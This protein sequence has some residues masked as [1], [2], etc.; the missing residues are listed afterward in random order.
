MPLPQ[1]NKQ[2]YNV[3]AL[4][5]INKLSASEWNDFITH[6]AAEL[7]EM[8]RKSVYD[9]NDDGV[10]NAAHSAE[11]AQA[12]LQADTIVDDGT[13]DGDIRAIDPAD[14]T[15]KW[16]SLIGLLNTLLGGTGWQ[17]GGG[18]MLAADYVDA[19]GKGVVRSAMGI[20]SSPD[21]LSFSR[22]S[23]GVSF[24]M[25]GEG[26]FSKDSSGISFDGS[27]TFLLG[28]VSIG[29]SLLRNIRLF[30]Y[31]STRD[32]GDTTRALYTDAGGNLRLGAIAG[33]A[34]IADLPDSS[35]LNLSNT[36]GNRYGVITAQTH[37]AYTIA[38][39]PAP[40]VGAV[41]LLRQQSAL[42]PTFPAEVI[43][44]NDFTTP[45]NPNRI[46]HIRLECYETTPKYLA[47]Y[48]GSEPG[49][50]AAWTPE[51]IAAFWWDVASLS[52]SDG[53]TVATL[54]DE[55]EGVNL[56]SSAGAPTYD[57]A[58]GML[59]FQAASNQYLK[60]AL[61]TTLGSYTV[62]MLVQMD[63]SQANTRAA[64]GNDIEQGLAGG[65]SLAARGGGQY[66]LRVNN[67]GSLG[68]N[69][70]IGASTK[71]LVTVVV[72]GASSEVYV[73]RNLS[74]AAQTYAA[75]LSSLVVGAA[76]EAGGSVSNPIELLIG[77][78]VLID[79]AISAQD[80]DDLVSYMET[81]HN[82]VS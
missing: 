17:T 73:N 16:M 53:A 54:A 27:T 64:W 10:V 7:G 21:G 75:D 41:V 60:A 56:A 62:S 1:N 66:A 34:T 59:R 14:S 70:T 23:G 24:E 8:M 35:E 76:A 50:A 47:W 48:E 32:D 38:A 45:W 33:L 39:S 67:A 9:V 68:G 20:E 61:G 30:A 40:A 3:S 74:S 15:Q 22:G 42:P 57:A 58:S 5:A 51:E 55:V 36:G 37:A 6:L 12:A 72:N 71:A 69:N 78:I 81:A 52:L 44:M 82:Y 11:L 18:D 77:D 2:D 25:G 28:D 79:G 49:V 43:L 19:A 4:P 46:H 26:I 31:P 65:I 80:L 63:A 13:D 29:D